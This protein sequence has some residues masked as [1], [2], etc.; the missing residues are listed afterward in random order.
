V[1]RAWLGREGTGCPGGRERKR[2]GRH[3]LTFK[4][5]TIPALFPISDLPL[6]PY[7]TY[8]NSFCPLP[9]PPSISDSPRCHA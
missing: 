7:L 3:L 1:R 6:H 8:L 9:P 5:K 2:R 4:K